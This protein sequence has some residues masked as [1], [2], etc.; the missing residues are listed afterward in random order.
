[1]WNK[2][3]VG[4]QGAKLKCL[5]VTLHHLQNAA[6]I[7]VLR[8]VFKTNE[9]HAA[10]DAWIAVFACA[11]ENCWHSLAVPCNG[12]FA[13]SDD[14]TDTTDATCTDSGSDDGDSVSD[15]DVQS[16]EGHVVHCDDLQLLEERTLATASCPSIQL[17][18]TGA[19]F[20]AC[21]GSRHPVPMKWFG[22]K[23]DVKS[24]CAIGVKIGTLTVSND[25]H[26]DKKATHG[27][28]NPARW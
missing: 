10:I 15:S 22:R 4:T 23:C 7:T 28:D 9:P 25:A 18:Q 12:S 21:F 17:M 16:T 13:D 8:V 26:N 6:D 11:I 19:Q 2:I 20:F 5:F 27:R 3:D 24:R 1:M 14:D